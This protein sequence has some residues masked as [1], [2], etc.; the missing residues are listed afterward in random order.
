MKLVKP[1]EMR[2]IDK[3]AIEE[4]GIPS[5]V[6]MENA[7]RGTVDEMEKEFGSVA[8]KKM[9]VVCGKGNNGGDGFV[10][11]RWLIKRKADVTV[12]L[13]GKEKDIS[14]DARINLEILLKMDTDIKEII[15]KDGLSLLSK[16][17][18]NADIVVDAIF[19][20]GFKG[21]IKGLTAHTVDL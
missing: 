8:S 2:E 6:L 20:T 18:N 15:N 10:I 5:I 12:F 4:V 14:G 17:L 13:I 11:A 7:G 9:V 21:D 16:S 19:G 3:R 1:D